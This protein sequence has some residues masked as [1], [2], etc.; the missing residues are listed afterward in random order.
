MKDKMQQDQYT[1]TQ[2]T[3]MIQSQTQTAQPSNTEGVSDEVSARQQLADCRDRLDEVDGQIVDL[4]VRRFDIVQQVGRIKHSQGWPVMDQNREN[5]KLAA[6]GCQAG[7]YDGQLKSLYR[8]IMGQS[9]ELEGST[10]TPVVNGLLFDFSGDELIRSTL[11]LMQDIRNHTQCSE[12]ETQAVRVGWAEKLRRIWAKL[13]K[14]GAARGWQGNLWQAYLTKAIISSNQPLAGLLERGGKLT[15]EQAAVLYQDMKVLLGLWQLDWQYPAMICQ[16]ELPLDWQAVLAAQVT[17]E[18]PLIQLQAAFAA[19]AG[20]GQE[21]ST[22]RFAAALL[23]YYRRYGYGDFS[24]YGGFTLSER[25]GEVVWQPT[26]GEQ[27]GRLDDIIGYER[28]KQTLV[29]NTELFL[30]GFQANHCLLY[31]AAGTGKSSCVR[32]LL[33]HY[34]QRGL[35]ILELGRDQLHLLPQVFERLRGRAHRWLILLDDLS[36]EEFEVEYKQLKVMMEGGL[37]GAPANVLFYATGNRRH[38]TQT[39]EGTK[40]GAATSDQK[41]ERLSLAARFGETILFDSPDRDE[42]NQIVLGL[43]KRFGLELEREEL[44]KR[45]NAWELMHHGRCGRSALQFIRSLQQ[46]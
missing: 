20:D 33:S 13:I 44:L 5:E 27:W 11:Q 32:A 25:N 7:V 26:V 43:A 3:E 37:T 18:Q 2:T 45:A 17:V 1:Q 15:P 40:F 16:V 28:Q 21:R 9:R 22:E 35:R 29:R 38:I 10:V 24:L 12:R 36:F 39:E 41:E 8:F 6:V 19:A 23:S 4:V 14:E 31:G 42:F 30:D 46:H 34:F